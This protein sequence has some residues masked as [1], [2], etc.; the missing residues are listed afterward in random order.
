MLTFRRRFDVRALKRFLI[1][2]AA[3]VALVAAMAPGV[4]SAAG[5]KLYIDDTAANNGGMA[6]PGAVMTSDF[7]SVT[8]AANTT[9]YICPG[10]YEG[11]LS[12]TEDNV[13]VIGK[14]FPR[15]TPGSGE[16]YLIQIDS[17]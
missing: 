11:V 4:A 1:A 17:A 3:P 5:A 9:V 15:L 10:N 12:I 7:T 2:A 13:K 8:I 16:S 6:C 14:G